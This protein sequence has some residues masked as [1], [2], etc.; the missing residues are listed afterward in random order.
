MSLKLGES[1]SPAAVQNRGSLN[2]HGL[3]MKQAVAS[4]GRLEYLATKTKDDKE[5]IIVKEFRY[6]KIEPKLISVPWTHGT[7]LKIGRLRPIVPMAQTYY[8]RDV[9]KHLNARYRRLLLPDAPQMKLTIELLDADSNPPEIITQYK[10]EALKPIYFHPNT[11][12]N[13]PVVEKKGFKGKGWEAEL[14]FGYAPVDKEYADLGLEKPTK[15]E[16][17]HV[18]IKNQGLDIIL[19]DRVIQFHVLSEIGLVQARHNDYNSIRG[20][21]DL[22]KGFSTAITKNAILQDE[23]FTESLDEI[24]QFLDERDYLKR[25]TYPEDLPEEL[26][27][28]RV[29]NWLKSN[30]ISPRKDVQSEF[31][32]QGLGGSIDILADG[33]PWEIKREEANGLDVYQLFAYLDMGDFTK[34]YL[35]AKAFSTGAEAAAIHI[36]TKHRKEI[37]LSKLEEFPVLHAMTDQERDKYY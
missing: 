27:R 33:E 19:H 23:H 26:L 24:K 31:A 8:S 36:Q 30:K 3:G 11:R 35:V 32:V 25:K 15:F 13:K 6:G 37:I 18:S 28:D 2:E 12:Q 9:V 7:E 5:A 1:I 22:K 17:Y 4:L 34:G 20:E 21:I 29:A 14:T 10:A 16:P